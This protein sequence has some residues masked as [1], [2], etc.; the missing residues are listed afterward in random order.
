MNKN[1]EM[2]TGVV[3]FMIVGLNKEAIPF[4]VKACPEL[5]LNGDWLSEEIEETLKT[6]GEAGFSVRAII[7]DNHS[8]NVNAFKSLRCK[9]GNAADVLSF[10]F[11]GQKIYNLYDSVHLI[12]NIR[13]NLLSAKR[14]FF[15][16]FK[17]DG[18]Y[19]PVSVDAGEISWRLLHDTYEKDLPANLRKSPKLNPKTLH[20]GNNKQNVPLAL[21]IF[22]ESTVAGILSY[23]PGESAAAGF[24]KLINKWWTIS[25]SKFMINT[26]N[27]L[28][29][30]AIRGD[31][32]SAFLRSFANWLEK[33]R[34]MQIS[35]CGKFTLTAH[36]FNALIVT[37]RGTAALL[38]DLFEDKEYKFV[39]TARLQTDPLE[40]N[41]GKTRQ[42][43]GGRFLISLREFLS[44]EKKLLMKSLL[45]ADIE[46]WDERVK[47]DPSSPDS[48]E[49]LQELNAIANEFEENILCADSREV[50]IHIAGYIT[51]KMLEGSKCN[52]CKNVLKSN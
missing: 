45:K 7:T 11:N 28:G 30:A 14:F 8:V 36:T 25:N 20:P 18:F 34:D 23:F 13:N 27:R 40:R 1:G 39:L 31:N 5:K 2:Y 16:S 26:N 41:F 47:C 32:K 15:P 52:D 42:M 46:C 10:N 6:M 29:N 24:L 38:E 49:L 35:G 17:F 51:K 4:V 22:D 9:Y 12:K 21:N 3:T 33:W 19:D 48:N 43:S 44:S 37:L 50:A